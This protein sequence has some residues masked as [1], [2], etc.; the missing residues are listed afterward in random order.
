MHVFEYLV[1]S[2]LNILM[3]IRR[4]GIVGGVSQGGAIE[5][6]NTHSITSW[7]LLPHVSQDVSFRQGLQ[8]YGCLPAAT[9]HALTVVESKPLKT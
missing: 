5:V 4:C 8:H 7:L 9:V 1:Y 2:H 6:S 3:R